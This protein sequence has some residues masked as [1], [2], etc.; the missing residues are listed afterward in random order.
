MP[1]EGFL[2][3]FTAKLYERIRDIEIFL[4]DGKCKNWE[5]YKKLVGQIKGARFAL[6]DMKDI[7]QRYQTDEGEI[8]E[9]NTSDSDQS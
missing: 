4:G 8:H 2:I 3:D 6:D 9:S 5:E 1:G 7:L